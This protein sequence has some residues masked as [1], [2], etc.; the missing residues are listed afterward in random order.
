VRCSRQSDTYWSYVTAHGPN[1]LSV[2][3]NSRVG[4]DEREVRRRSWKG[5][6][7]DM[8]CHCRN[9]RHTL[10]KNLLRRWSTQYGI[11]GRGDFQLDLTNS[12]DGVCSQRVSSMPEK[13]T[14]RWKSRSKQLMEGDMSPV[15]CLGVQMNLAPSPRS[16]LALG[17]AVLCGVR[18]WTARLV[19]S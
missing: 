15:V 7:F 2:S 11:V 17:G 18:S 16:D 6:K 19:G 8:A 4:W 13:N 3:G 14:R 10:T 1:L 12:L 5:S 9:R